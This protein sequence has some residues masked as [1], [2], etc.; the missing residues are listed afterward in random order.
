MG[1]NILVIALIWIAV[2][3]FVHDNKGYGW[4]TS[5]ILAPI[6]AIIIL[7]EIALGKDE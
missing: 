2:A 6:L 7:I 1:W 3:I 5:F 4:K